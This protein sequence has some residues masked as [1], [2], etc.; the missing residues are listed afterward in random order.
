MWITIACN[1]PMCS[2]S[3]KFRGKGRSQ[4]FVCER[5]ATEENF[6]YHTSK[7][8]QYIFTWYDIIFLIFNKLGMHLIVLYVFNEIYKFLAKITEISPTVVIGDWGCRR[9]KLEMPT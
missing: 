1:I 2:L 6:L 3:I 9:E 8:Y 7:K 5:G 4:N